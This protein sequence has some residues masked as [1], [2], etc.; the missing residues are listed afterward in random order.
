[1]TR[2]TID[3]KVEDLGRIGYLDGLAAQER[4][5]AELRQGRGH[6]TLLLLEHPPVLTLGRNA[7]AAHVLASPSELTQRGVEVFEATRGGDVT[8]HGPGQLVG[9]PVM[10][11]PEGRRG[12]HAYVRDL[13]EALIR[14]LADFGI[15]GVRDSGYPGVWVGREKIA[16]LGVRIAGWVT[17]HGFALNVDPELEHFRLIT[18]CGLV[19]R[20]VTSMA[21]LRPADVPSMAQVKAAVT[22]NFQTVF[23]S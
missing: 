11:L 17:T 6:A 14:T 23:A 1:M 9:Y 5:A 15:P 8:Y 19:G 21:R 20:G 4:V 16:A 10:L 22:R 7:S 3:L 18:P 12:V 13:E 2:P